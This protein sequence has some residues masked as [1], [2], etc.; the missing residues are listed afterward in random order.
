MNLE[1]VN[2]VERDGVLPIAF[3]LVHQ[4]L[5]EDASRAFAGGPAA[6]FNPAWS[7]RMGLA[8]AT[9][10]KAES[11]TTMM[12]QRIGDYEAFH[13]FQ[14]RVF[15]SS[16][17]FVAEIDPARFDDVIVTPPYPDSL[18]RTFSA[19]LAEPGGITRCDAIE[20]WIVQHA[21]RHLGEIEHARSLVGLGGLT[22]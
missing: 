18:A 6:L 13:D 9:D 14:R 21:L 10:G 16:E 1:Q 5:I 3:S 8:L 15:A 12:H 20:S 22:S 4:A 2:H 11:V 19:R 17:Q 7:A